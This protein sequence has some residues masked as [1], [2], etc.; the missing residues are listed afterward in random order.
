M[1]VYARQ[2]IKRKVKKGELALYGDKPLKKDV[3]FSLVRAGYADGLNRKKTAGLLNN[4]CMDMSA[5]ENF[6]GRVF[7]DA[8]DA[9]KKQN[10]ISYEI[11]CAATVRAEKKYLR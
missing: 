2:I 5:V 3:E 11:L 6:D 4:R 7:K 10:T 9:A 8:E 1:K